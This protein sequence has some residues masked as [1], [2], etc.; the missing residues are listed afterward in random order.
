MSNLEERVET[1]LLNPVNQLGYDIY[2][3]EY[4]KSGKDYYLRIYIEKENGSIT[5]E[6]CEKVSNAISDIL[7]EEDYIKEQYFLEV[8]S[9]GIEKTLRKEK[10]LEQNLEQEIE[11]SL[12]RPIEKQKKIR[13]IL[14]EFDEN[15]IK[16][17][18]KDEIIQI[19]RK[20]I[21]LIKTV[22]NW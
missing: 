20:E 17:L 7:D 6:D 11:L 15:S 2:D 5:L 12:F 14:K 21:S 10:H 3:V 8:S 4:V 18:V 19:D 22:Y 16:L 9:T 1:T 13:G